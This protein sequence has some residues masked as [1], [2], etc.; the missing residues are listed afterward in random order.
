M[1]IVKRAIIMAAGKGTRMRPLTYK[2]PKPLIKVNGTPMI[3]SIIESLR[4]NN[5]GEIYVVVGYLGDQFQYLSDKYPGLNVIKNPYYEI[6]NNISSMYVVRD[7]LEDS[8]ILDGDQLITNP[9]ILSP[10]FAISGYAAIWTEDAYHEWMLQLQNNYIV[11]CIR[12]QLMTGW[13]LYS[14][15]RWNSTD[16]KALRKWIE[17]EF[18]VM[19]N[20]SIYW[21]DVPVFLHRDQ[22]QLAMTRI[23]A[24]DVQEIDSISQLA[25]IDFNYTRYV[26]EETNHAK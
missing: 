16:G 22:F 12:D 13:R 14:I 15:S 7:F 3:E 5:I 10:K 17:Y 11:G 26:T 20:R 8:I 6:Y 2:T 1:N 18:E 23:E 21:D 9:Q 24:D 25:R 4:H 19:Q